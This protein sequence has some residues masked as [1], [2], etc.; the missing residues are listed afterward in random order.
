MY[1]EDFFLTLS[2]YLVDGLEEGLRLFEKKTG[3]QL[4]WTDKEV[5]IGRVDLMS[6]IID[7]FDPEAYAEV[8]ETTE[9]GERS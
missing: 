3:I 5:F 1:A 8:K 9:N 4:R 6:A 2:P 7:T